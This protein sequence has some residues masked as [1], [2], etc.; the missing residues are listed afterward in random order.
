MEDAKSDL[1]IK[2]YSKVIEWTIDPRIGAV[3]METF[4]NFEKDIEYAKKQTILTFL[5]VR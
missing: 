3:N 4:Y 5:F 2:L 1:I